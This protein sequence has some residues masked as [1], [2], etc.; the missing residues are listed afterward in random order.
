MLI[1]KRDKYYCVELTEL[2]MGK[3]STVLSE[4]KDQQE[5]EESGSV[6]TKEKRFCRLFNKQLKEAIVKWE[7]LE[8]KGVDRDAVLLLQKRGMSVQ[9]IANRFQVSYKTVRYAIESKKKDEPLII[10]NDTLPKGK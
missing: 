6:Y 10:E 7:S 2:E 4:W 5:T 3:L 8:T 1:A 9:K